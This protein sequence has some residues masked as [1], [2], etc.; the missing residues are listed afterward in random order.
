MTEYDDDF[1]LPVAFPPREPGVTLGSV[2]ADAGYSQLRLAETEKYA[3]VTY[4]LNGG[5]E[6]VFEGERREIVPSPDVPTYDQHPEMSAAAVT[7]E[8]LDG[9]ADSAV[10]V[11][12]YANPDMVGHTGEFDATV[13][14]VETVDEQLGRLTAATQERD[15][16]V[17]IIADHGNAEQMG[18]VESPHTAHTTNPV[19]FVYC[20]PDGD[21]GGRQAN[22]GELADIAPT[23]L[24]LLG[25]DCPPT[26]TG[27]PLLSPST[28]SERRG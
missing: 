7:D 22:S 13:R 11:L 21:D 20:S 2:L 23:I 8:A 6:A 28:G 3:H 16:H 18:T 17:V 24:A 14:A 26:M 15:A 12:N 9:L 19:P 4:F 27:R 5:R 25:V 10:L 1:D